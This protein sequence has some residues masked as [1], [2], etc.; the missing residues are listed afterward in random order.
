MMQSGMILNGA[1]IFGAA[2]GRLLGGGEAGAEAIVGVN[3]LMSMIK[4]AVGDTVNYGGVNVVVYGAPGQDVE[5][6]ADI[7]SDRINAQVASRRAVF[8]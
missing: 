7:I 2:N 4:S 8:A 6:L 5:E 3:S 1:T